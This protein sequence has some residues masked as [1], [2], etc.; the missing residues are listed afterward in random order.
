MSIELGRALNRDGIFPA[1]IFKSCW[2]TKFSTSPSFSGRSNLISY[3]LNIGFPKWRLDAT[4][5]TGHTGNTFPLI[6]NTKERRPS[7]HSLVTTEQERK[8]KA[9]SKLGEISKTHTVARRCPKSIWVKIDET[10]SFL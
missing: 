7:N 2:R 6:R 9:C 3:M 10:F 1:F 8:M 4:L 5:T